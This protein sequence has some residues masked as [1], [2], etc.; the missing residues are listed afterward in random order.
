MKMRFV[1]L[2]LAACGCFHRAT[3]SPSHERSS[4][5]F[6]A[7][8]IGI[9]AV[10]FNDEVSLARGL[11]RREALHAAL[12]EQ[13][14]REG[15]DIVFVERI[16]VEYGTD[17][18]RV[19]RAVDSLTKGARELVAGG[20]EL[21]I[22][23]GSTEALIAQRTAPSIPIVFW[24]A[25]P[26][27]EGVVASLERP[28]GSATGVVPRPDARGELLRL[29]D[30]LAPG[31]GPIAYLFNS[32]YPAGVGTLEQTRRAAFS[33]GM[34]LEVEEVRDAS[35]L[36]AAFATFKTRGA[37]A[38]LVGNHGLFRRESGRI[39]ELSIRYRLPLLSPYPEA[40]DAGALVSCVP[41]FVFWSRRAA[42]FVDLILKGA[43][44]AVLAVEQSVPH[45]C[46]L[47]LV[48]AA[49]LQMGIPEAVL[50]RMDRVIR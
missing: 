29:L 8:R 7:H 36:E 16:E 40:R 5:P 24:S 41:D 26:V 35:A 21:I 45:S 39:V 28:G 3:A 1:V 50:R 18:E 12:R 33:L 2:L 19:R 17:P 32:T 9:L 11:P 38:L 27:A 47:N 46:T 37:R 10:A 14:Y 30:A 43:Q 48:T 49:A 34:Q 42:V 23:S 6:R 22:A 4:D 15:E 13:G 20:V 25:D 31:D 44:P